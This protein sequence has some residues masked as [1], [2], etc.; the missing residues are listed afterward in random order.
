MPRQ[1]SVFRIEEL[2]R[3]RARPPTSTADEA[4]TALRHT[5][6]MTELK[7]LRAL[8]QARGAENPGADLPLQMQNEVEAL[9]NELNSIYRAINQTKEEIALLHL[10]GFSDA[11]KG[12]VTNELDA[13][14]GGSE[15]ATHRIL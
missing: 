6:M 15:Q 3:R 4:E 10:T 7:V 13:V 12:R 5:E 1:R 9:K 8:L 2:V 14:V 11:E